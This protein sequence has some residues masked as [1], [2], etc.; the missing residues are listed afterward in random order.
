[1][2]ML[3]FLPKIDSYI[4]RNN[5]LHLH[6]NCSLEYEKKWGNVIWDWTWG[7]YWVLGL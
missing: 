7:L 6:L 1:M 3:L 2:K 5:L 4:S